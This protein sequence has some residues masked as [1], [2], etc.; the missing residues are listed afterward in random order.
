[1][2]QLMALEAG[3]NLVKKIFS[4]KGVLIVIGIIAAYFVVK[5]LYRSYNESRFDKDETERAN[6]LALQYRNASNPSGFKNMIDYDGTSTDTILEK[7]SY[8]TKGIFKKVAD[9]YKLKFDETLS[10]RMTNELSTS[11]LNEWNNIVT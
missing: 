6:Q 1:M 5:K 4:T 8:Q 2:L 3:G 7:L 11:E 9:A 10:D